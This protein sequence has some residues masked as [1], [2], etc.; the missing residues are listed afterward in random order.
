MHGAVSIL[1]MDLDSDYR[2]FCSIFGIQIHCYSVF[3]DWP[4]LRGQ[5]LDTDL[6]V[7]EYF[8]AI[9]FSIEA[10]STWLF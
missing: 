3:T 9:S 6:D 5:A 8:L 10:S 2:R 1:Y 7:S 4:R